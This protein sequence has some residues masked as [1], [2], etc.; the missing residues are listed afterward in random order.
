MTSQFLYLREFFS[1]LTIAERMQTAW[2]LEEDWTEL[3]AR[4]D[5]FLD[6]R[7][8]N[9]YSIVSVGPQK[10][11]A[12]NLRYVCGSDI[13]TDPNSTNFLDGSFYTWQQACNHAPKGCRLPTKSDLM[14]LRDN[15]DKDVFD[16]DDIV[17]G[18]F[19]DNVKRKNSYSVYWMITN[20]NEKAHVYSSSFVRGTPITTSAWNKIYFR[21]VTRYL[22]K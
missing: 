12:E 13:T 18:H 11:L 19:E 17:P 5:V 21:F 16:L 22:L 14:N 8:Y 15:Y 7:D 1:H 20:T 10:W 3:I 4:D 9:L 6:V 2:D